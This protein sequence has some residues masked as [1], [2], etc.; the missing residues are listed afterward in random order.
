MPAPER[1]GQA[2]GDAFFLAALGSQKLRQVF[3]QIAGDFARLSSRKDSDSGG[4]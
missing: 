4:A 3:A 1:F 2:I